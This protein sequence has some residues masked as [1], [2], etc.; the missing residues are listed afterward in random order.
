MCL[1]SFDSQDRKARA[2]QYN[3]ALGIDYQLHFVSEILVIRLEVDFATLLVLQQKESVSVQIHNL[4]FINVCH[5]AR[6]RD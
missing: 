2:D 4:D 1:I 6:Q 3:F 5:S